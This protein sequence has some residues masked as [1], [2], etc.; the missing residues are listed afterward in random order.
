MSTT[1]LIITNQHGESRVELSEGYM[2]KVGRQD[3]NDVVI[4]SEIVSRQHAMLQRAEDGTFY[5]IDMGSR[6]G[7]FVNGSRVSVPAALH[8]GDLISLGDTVIKFHCETTGAA[9]AAPEKK[10]TGNT[11]KAYFALNRTTLLVIDVRNFTVLTQKID[12]GL[13]CQVIGTW[14]R[15]AGAVLETRGSWAQKYIGDA[16]MSTW[17]HKHG[18]KPQELVEVL[19]ALVE[20]VRMTATLQARFGLQQPIRI[21]AGVNTGLASIGNAA[22]SGSLTDYTA[23]GDTVN[24]AFRLESAT[25]DAGVD[26][27]LGQETFEWLAEVTSPEPYFVARTV[28]LK[29]YERAAS[30]WGAKFE[31]LEKF[32][33]ALPA[34]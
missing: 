10:L 21:G 22:G 11:T 4:P 31:D 30:A 34:A 13:L 7:S 29:G 8:D 2:W 5:L 24:A 27:L 23:M 9:P 26:V 6:N 3:E 15:E 19:R 1:H 33:D 32:V 20:L 18:S 17:V 28:N 25:K 16:I 14:F 12:Q